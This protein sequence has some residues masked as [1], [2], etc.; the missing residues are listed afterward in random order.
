M[1]QKLVFGVF[2]H[3]DVGG[4]RVAL[5]GFGTHDELQ[6]GFDGATAVDET[7]REE[8]E[9]FGMRG[10]VAEFAEVIDTGDDTTT[11]DVMPEAVD[12]DARGER[13]VFQIRHVLGELQTTAA[14]GVE[15]RGI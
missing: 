3:G 14:L 10:Q 15:G 8:V 2:L 7:L 5:K 13:V 6:H 9:Q 1:A 11:K 4:L 12:D